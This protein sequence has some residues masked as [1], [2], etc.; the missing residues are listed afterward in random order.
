MGTLALNRKARFNYE[1]LEKF[2]AGIELRGVEVKSILMGRAN[3]QGAY[4]SIRGEEAWLLGAHV[5]PYQPK[6]A[7]ADYESDRTRRLL[8]RKQEIRILIGKTKERGLTLVP[9]RMY[10]K[11]GKIKVELGLCR[12]R[13]KHD[14]RELIKRREAEREIQRHLRGRKDSTGTFS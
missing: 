9:L 11:G 4:A 3:M 13:K 1:I 10:A 6:N 7:P 5:P 8:L 12:A 2:E 14:K